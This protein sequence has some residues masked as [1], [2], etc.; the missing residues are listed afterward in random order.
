M[1]D[2]NRR[3]WLSPILRITPRR[4]V[5]FMIFAAMWWG[6]QHYFTPEKRAVRHRL[7]EA[8]SKSEAAIDARLK[9]LTA[10]FAKGRKGAKAFA[11]ECSRGTANGST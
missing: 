2:T 11:K 5:V 3:T 6:Y 8:D 7:S 10:L 9:P 4:I 1:T